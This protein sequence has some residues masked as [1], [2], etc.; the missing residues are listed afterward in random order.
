VTVG[1]IPAHV[2]TP[3]PAASLAWAT[4]AVGAWAQ[5]IHLEPITASRWH[6][7]HILTIEDGS[8]TVHVVLRRWARPGWEIDDPDFDARREATALAWLAATPVPA[9]ELIAVDY[10]GEITDVPALLM[11]VL[12]G[13]PPAEE[14][15]DP[16]RFVMELARAMVEVHAVPVGAAP[17]YRPWCDLGSAMPPAWVP[18]RWHRLWEIVRNGA[19]HAEQR[20]IHRDFHHGNTLWSSG[21]LVGIVDWTTAS[22]GSRGVDVAHARWNLALDFGPEL[23]ASF[24]DAYRELAPDYRHER[25]WDAAQVVDWLGDE[26][27]SGTRLGR[28]DRYLSDVLG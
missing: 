8:S 7:N 4:A 23:A 11:T 24:L 16:H 15:Y 25:Y 10:D 5:V 28:L 22:I 17:P 1:S 2:L 3:P 9:P 18:R 20:F 14:P 13:W 21:E 6:A 12:P 19:R 26:P 27:V